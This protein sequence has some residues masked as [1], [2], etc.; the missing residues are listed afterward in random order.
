MNG[1]HTDD[2]SRR[3]R[4][5]KKRERLSSRPSR[6]EFDQDFGLKDISL[7]E[8]ETPTV[9]GD[10]TPSAGS[11]SGGFYYVQMQHELDAAAE[12]RRR[13]RKEKQMATIGAA[14]GFTA[15]SSV[16]GGMGGP[17]G[18]VLGGAIGSMIGGGC[19]IISACTS[20][21]SYEVKIA[22]EYRDNILDRVTLG[23]YYA[24]CELVVPLIDKSRFV[25]LFTKKFL[26]D[27][28]IDYFEVILNYK[29]ET[30][31]MTSEI[32]T[33]AFLRACHLIGRNVDHTAWRAL[34]K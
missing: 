10:W 13:E 12:A 7:M 8:D 33:K 30:H 23:G 20:P 4:T 15:A 2:F 21:Q 29:N 26:V 6:T 22:R 18:A 24:L 27:K 11:R 19:I 5:A 17:A 9:R 25:K 3:L 32:V 1:M 34:H 28:M 14:V 16:S 31:F